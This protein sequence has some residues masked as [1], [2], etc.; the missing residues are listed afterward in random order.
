MM[1]GLGLE[2]RRRGWTVKQALGTVGND[3]CSSLIELSVPA[4]NGVRP[5]RRRIVLR[6]RAIDTRQDRDR[7]T[8][9]CHRAR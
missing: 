9:V 3:V 6:A 4:P 8:L 2:V 5:L 7:L 1:T